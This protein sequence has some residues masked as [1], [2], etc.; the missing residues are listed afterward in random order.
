MEGFILQSEDGTT[1][2]I[3]I[4]LGQV[5][6]K[7]INSEASLVSW[8]DVTPTSFKSVTIESVTLFELI[9][10]S[11]AVNQS[12]VDTFRRKTLY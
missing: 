8:H 6:Y 4:F 2:V 9:H 11:Y 3:K 12:E 10:K 1:D 7:G 5:I